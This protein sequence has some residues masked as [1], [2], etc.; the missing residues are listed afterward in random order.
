MNKLV[1][2][3]NTYHCSISKN[4]INANYSALTEKILVQVTLKIGQEKYLLLI[5]LKNYP[6]TLKIKDLHREK[7]IGSFCGKE[8]LLSIS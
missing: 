7:I 1:D 8:L 3:Y 6:W 4:P 2:Q 5:A